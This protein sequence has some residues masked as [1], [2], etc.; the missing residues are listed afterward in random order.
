MHQVSADAGI[1]AV[2]F[3]FDLKHLFI[4]VDGA[5]PLIE[6][7]GGGLELYVKFLKPSGFRLVLR[8]DGDA[9]GVQL[10][11]RA[12]DA[13]WNG[14]LARGLTAAVGSVAEIGVPFAALKVDSHDAVAFFVA[15]SRGETQVEQHPKHRPIELTVPDAGFAA[16]SWTA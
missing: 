2:E 7:L 5:R 13:G 1:I 6:I 3:G 4:R 9:I 11:E 8:V 12:G 16:S 10:A 15:L 14:R